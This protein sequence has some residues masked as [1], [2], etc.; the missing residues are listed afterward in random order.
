MSV[1]L[2]SNKKM[3]NLLQSSLF[4][5][6]AATGWL[7]ADSANLNAQDQP[8][9]GN[10]DPQQMRQRMS[11]RMREQFGITDE[12]EWKL[13]FERINK[14]MEA[15]RAAGGFGG[16][17][18]FG[19]GMMRPPGG[20]GGPPGGNSQEQGGPPPGGPGGPGGFGSS[21]GGPGGPFGMRPSS[22]EVEALRKA[23][24]S[25]ASNEELKARIADVKAARVKNQAALAKA[26]EELKQVMS[27]QQEAVATSMG[28]L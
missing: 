24:E 15:R 3:K 16:P 19:G 18:G 11:E 28:L 9:P 26:Q 22:P 12:S 1:R 8:P 2:I 5:A 21:P 17:G 13:I 10:F 14:V 20:P 25:K 7:L 27:L 6:C 23:I 4:V